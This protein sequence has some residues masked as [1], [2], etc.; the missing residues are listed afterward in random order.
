MVGLC[1]IFME[2][3]HSIHKLSH[4]KIRETVPGTSTNILT[5]FVI[6]N[7]SRTPISYLVE[8]LNS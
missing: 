1:S 5:H 7:Y 3:A 4:F 6:L 2:K 8:L